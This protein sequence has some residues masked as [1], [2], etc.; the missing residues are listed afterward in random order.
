MFGHFHLILGITLILQARIL[1]KVFDSSGNLLVHL[2]LSM[3]L[4]TLFL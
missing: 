1:I 3:F 2:L 4:H